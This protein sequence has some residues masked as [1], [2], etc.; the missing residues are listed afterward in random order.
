MINGSIGSSLP[1]LTAFRYLTGSAQFIDD[2]K[3]PG[4]VSAHFLRSPH[5]HAGIEAI[6]CREA[7][8]APG[9]LGVW[10]GKD[11]GSHVKGLLPVVESESYRCSERPPLAVDQVRFVGEAVAVIVAG[12]RYLAEDAAD[13]VQIDYHPL[14][15]VADLFSSRSDHGIQL[16]ATAEDNAMFRCE[17]EGGNSGHAFQNAD[18][19]ITRTFQHPRCTGLAVENRGVVARYDPGR[20]ALTVWSSTQVPDLLR[21]AVAECLDF[22]ANKLRVITL[23]VGGGFGVKMHVFPEELI[24]PFLARELRRP[25]KWIEDRRENLMASVHARDHVLHAEIAARKD[26]TILALRVQDIGDV[27][28]YSS[29]PCSCALDPL[30]CGS[31]LPGPYRIENYSFRGQAVATNKCPAGAIR[32]VGFVLATLVTER[33]MDTVARALQMDPAEIRRRN[34][35]A[36][37]EF[38]YHSPAGIVYDSGDHRATLERALEAADYWGWRQKQTELRGQRRYIGIGLASFIEPTGMGRKVFRRRGMTEI[39]AFDSATVKVDPC[40]TTRAY[41]STPSQGQGQETTFAQL[42]ADE[43]GLRI[44][45]VSISLGDTESCPSGNGTFASRSLVSAGSALV[46]AAREMRRKLLCAAG[47]ILRVSPDEL[48]IHDGKICRS[49]EQEPALIPPDE[50]MGAGTWDQ[51]DCLLS[52]RELSLAIYSPRHEL[53]PDVNFEMETTRSFSAQGAAVSGG[54]HLAVVEV[55]PETGLVNLLQYVVAED[56]GRVI[57]PAIV[58]G[59]I[60]GGVVQGIGSALLE[61]VLY[62]SEGQV[63]T[64]T[65]MDYLFPGSSDVVPINIEHLETLSP[66]TPT[67]SKGVGES[68]IIASPAAIGN[69]ISDALSPFEVSFT[70]LPVTPQE[71]WEALRREERHK[72][73]PQR[74]HK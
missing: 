21:K 8:K 56:S 7:L 63:L 16:Q 4:M 24:I 23:D 54:T 59:Q 64:A 58:D 52:V 39:P 73:S 27:G 13:L 11:I 18:V 30:T 47:R 9:V 6:D 46:L 65:L 62:D 28:A 44:E 50:T 31:A 29:Y 2:L 5:A 20:Q 40:G 12:D 48:A 19:R 25:V 35:I 51:N 22:P 15:P 26:G 45:D 60:R 34:F 53:Q 43:M 61:N 67:G 33:L 36:P 17:I 70:K 3:F 10:T 66:L 32:G 49:K 1:S 41:L 71:I 74:T 69:A 42:L 38:P 37:R 68:G 14:N 55:D 72:D 57:N